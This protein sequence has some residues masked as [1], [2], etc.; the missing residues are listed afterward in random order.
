[1]SQRVPCELCG[2]SILEVTAKYNDGMCAPCVQGRARKE[3][4]EYIKQNK[5]D[6]NRFEGVD[7]DVEI[8]KIMHQP[9]K[10]DTLVNN[11][12][13]HK[14]LYELYRDLN[15]Q[16]VYELVEYAIKLIQDKDQ[17]QAEEVLIF[18]AC[19]T[20]VNLDEALE[21]CIENEIFYPDGIYREC[22]PKVSSKLLK[23]I[24]SG[25]RHDIP[26]CLA[27]GTDAEVVDFFKRVE[28][29]EPEEARKLSVRAHEFSH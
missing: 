23:V 3:R 12:P 6:V 17:D 28:G 20:K 5:K 7:S 27:Y 15:N 14:K 19:M 10:Y 26:G 22:G 11:I 25:W 24:E 13:Y 9:K 16:E 8:I 18:L 1:M 4:E 29:N 21:L 2:T